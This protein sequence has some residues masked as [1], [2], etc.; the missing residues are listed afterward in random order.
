MKVSLFSTGNFHFKVDLDRVCVRAYGL[1]I[2]HA[3]FLLAFDKMV[4]K[5]RSTN[6]RGFFWKEIP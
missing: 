3:C 6:E 1:C 4:E 2:C 5:S